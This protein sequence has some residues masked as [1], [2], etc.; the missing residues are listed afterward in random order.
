MKWFRSGRLD[1]GTNSTII[2][3]G[4][5]TKVEFHYSTLCKTP[6]YKK[7]QSLT[8]E[9]EKHKKNN[10][11]MEKHHIRIRIHKEES[12]KLFMNY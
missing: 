5:T 9:K 12:A 8:K 6:Q 10:A 7:H 11:M 4:S 2:H 1:L 3:L